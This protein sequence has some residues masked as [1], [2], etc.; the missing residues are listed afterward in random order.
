MVGTPIGN[1][2]D[3]APRAR[4]ALRDADVIACEDTRRT[5]ALLS[6]I[7]VPAG[8]RLRSVHAHNEYERAERIVEEIAGGQLVAYV[9][10]AGMPGISDPGAELVRAC[11]RA[12]RAVEVLPGPTALTVALVLSGLPTDRF[13]FDGFLPRKGT[14]RRTR[15]AAYASETR[16]AVLYESP[17]RVAATLADLAAVCGPDRPVA[18][19]R[20]LTKLHEEAY[21]GTLGE[22]AALATVKEARGEH[23]IVLGGAPR[24]EVSH[25]TVVDAVRDALD[26]GASARDAATAVAAELGVAR[27]RAYEV[28][29]TLRNP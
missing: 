10:D 25:D 12:G 28:A 24:I 15:L 9:T 11:L 29:L 22:A 18:V 1:L 26:S 3:L 21:R 2:G 14:E 27:R 6:A 19:V 13:V 7:E 20:E 17:R 16:T 8:N 23:V 5:R 4:D